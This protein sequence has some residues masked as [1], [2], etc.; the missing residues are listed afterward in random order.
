MR[1]NSHSS[2]DIGLKRDETKCMRGYIRDLMIIGRAV[3]VEEIANITGNSNTSFSC[4]FQ[5]TTPR[6]KSQK[7]GDHVLSK[8]LPSSVS[9]NMD[10]SFNATLSSFTD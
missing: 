7:L 4:H 2:Y 6:R 3:T 9:D 8:T 1:N 10:P 5:G